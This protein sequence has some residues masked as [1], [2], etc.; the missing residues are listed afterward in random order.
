MSD[1]C[2]AIANIP[3]QKWGNLYSDE[4]ALNIGTVFQDLNMPF[5]ASE[6]AMRDKASIAQGTKNQTLSDR[7]MMMEKIYQIGFLLDDLTLYL[8]THEKDQQAIQLYHQKAD[9]YANIRKQFAQ[10]YYPLSRLC[11]PDDNNSNE[12]VFCWTEGPMP[13]EGACV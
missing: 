1:S 9:E 4:E 6:A 5:F 12:T 11:I 2:L 13:W 3:I 10:K 7:E 8:D